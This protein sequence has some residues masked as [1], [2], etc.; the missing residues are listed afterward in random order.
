MKFIGSTSMV[1]VYNLITL[2]NEINRSPIFF[3]K[4]KKKDTK[5]RIM[6]DLAVVFQ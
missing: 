1:S 3:H 2:N 6:N 4:N 5:E